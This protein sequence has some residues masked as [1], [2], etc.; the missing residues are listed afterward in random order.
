VVREIK[1]AAAASASSGPIAM[2]WQRWVALPTNTGLAAWAM[3]EM[4][5]PKPPHTNACWPSIS[6]STAS[7]AMPLPTCTSAS[8]IAQHVPSTNGPESAHELPEAH[9]RHERPG[10]VAPPSSFLAGGGPTPPRP[11]PLPELPGAPQL[12]I[13]T[14]AAMIG[15]RWYTRY[16]RR[17]PGGTFPAVARAPS[18]V[19]E[20]V[21]GLLSESSVCVTGGF[22][23]LQG[24]AYAPIRSGA[25]D[26]MTVVRPVAAG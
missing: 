18:D 12:A 13:A 25:N 15:N 19:I 20:L 16:L 5:A 6:M 4:R 9:G 24:E 7:A 8:P 22:V 1:D 21:V 26:V 11:G 2:R 17:K 10:H 3:F 23:T 14:S